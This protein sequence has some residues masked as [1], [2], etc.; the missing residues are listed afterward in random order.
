M[1]ELKFYDNH[2]RELPFDAESQQYLVPQ[3]KKWVV[4]LNSNGS[5]V[6]HVKSGDKLLPLIWDNEAEGFVIPKNNL[7]MQNAVS[8]MSGNLILYDDNDAALNPGLYLI[9]DNISEKDFAEI[10][11]RLGQLAIA[12]ESGVLAPVTVLRASKDQSTNL[13][14]QAR[15]EAFEHLSQVVNDNW[16]IIKKKTGYRNTVGNKSYRFIQASGLIFCTLLQ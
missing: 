16:E 1:N 5:F 9:P 13:N 11:D 3:Y 6:P 8:G 4:R 15:I 2:L 12:N 7:L 14:A 10:L